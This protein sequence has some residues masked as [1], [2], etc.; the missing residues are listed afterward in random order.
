M[1]RANKESSIAEIQEAFSRA[2]STVFV[3]YSGMT[4]AEVSKLRDICRSK[5]VKYKVLKNTLVRK[6][7]GDAPYVDKLAA[8]LKGMT[9]IAW[10]FEEPSAAAR[11]LKDYAKENEKLKIK[12]GLLEGQVLDGKA[13]ETQLA[14]LPSKDE[15]RAMLLATFN[16]PAQ[17]FVMLLNAPAGSFVRVLQAKSNQG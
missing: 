5:G 9:A 8:N 2:T 12:A 1:L 10:S 3:D 15:A 16:A 6:A 17:Q 14:T 7:L 13:V 4:V 11:L